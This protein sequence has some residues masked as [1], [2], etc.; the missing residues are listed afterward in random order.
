M[1]QRN[2]IID[3]RK[4]PALFRYNCRSKR[5]KIAENQR[6]PFQIAPTKLLQKRFDTTKRLLYNNR[7]LPQRELAGVHYV[8]NFPV[9]ER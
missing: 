3:Q 1:Y 7:S 4:F 9:P 5:G 2:N 8:T 6:N